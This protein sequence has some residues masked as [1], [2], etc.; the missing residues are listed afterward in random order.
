MSIVSQIIGE[1]ET[2]KD[3]INDALA[4]LESDDLVLASSPA[5]PMD[6]LNVIIELGLV[7][8]VVIQLCETGKHYRFIQYEVNGD[9][10]DFLACFRAL[11]EDDPELQDKD[12]KSDIESLLN[13]REK[14]H[15]VK[16]EAKEKGGEA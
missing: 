11:D 13:R 4:V 6:E 15:F 3:R 10:D 9:C 2:A 8:G 14:W 16:D 7:P 1:L 12:I 5:L